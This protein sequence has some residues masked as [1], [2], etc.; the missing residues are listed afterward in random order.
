MTSR[1]AVLWP[2][3]SHGEHDQGLADV[4]ATACVQTH[5]QH[6]AIADYDT[7]LVSEQADEAYPE[8][9]R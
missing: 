1:R 2:N 7:A 3:P 4:D 5:V 9:T 6:L 8:V